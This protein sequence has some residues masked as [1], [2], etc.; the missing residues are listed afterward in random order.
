MGIPCVAAAAAALELLR[1]TAKF[2]V[3][4]D[5]AL[6]RGYVLSVGG[7]ELDDMLVWL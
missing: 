4:V 7:P 5:S 6:T 2:P 1:R 3:W